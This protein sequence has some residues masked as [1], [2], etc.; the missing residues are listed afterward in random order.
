MKD[1]LLLKV[2]EAVVQLEPSAEV[3]LYGS[4]A[5]NDFREYSD[6]DFLILVDGV[7]DTTR[8]DRV[9]RVLF[10]IE[11]DTDQIISSI[12]R[13][14]QDWNSPRYSVVPLYKN[15]EREGILI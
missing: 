1:I 14:R 15:I 12:I 9:R 13:S 8:T 4:R 7:V 6:W 10:E 3:I 2:K 11:L 5:R